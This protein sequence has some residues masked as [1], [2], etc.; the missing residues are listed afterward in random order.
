MNDNPVVVLYKSKACGSCANLSKIWDD[1]VI[2]MKNIKPTI[3]FFTVE[4]PDAFGF[5]DFSKAPKDLHRYKNS[6][7]AIL[8]VPGPLW[9]AAM[10]NLG[11]NNNVQITDGVQL[12]NG[13]LLDSVPKMHDKIRYAYNKPS[14]FARWLKDSLENED[15]KRVQNSS[16]TFPK[17]MTKIENKPVKVT[18]KIEFDPEVRHEPNE[19]LQYSLSSLSANVCSLKMI[20]RPKKLVL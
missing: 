13:Y 16:L 20:S 14:E 8:L 6:F 3:R 4:S 19:K 12:F 2:E 18:N 11:V 5:F 1:I 10:T 9:N 7:P 15:F 17:I